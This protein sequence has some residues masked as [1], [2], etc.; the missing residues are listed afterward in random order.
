MDSVDVHNIKRGQCFSN[1]CDCVGYLRVQNVI[2]CGYCD[3]PP[4]KHLRL[5]GMI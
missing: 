2:S 5:I 3:C 1:D 4:A